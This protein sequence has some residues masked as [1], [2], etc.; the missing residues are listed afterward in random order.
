MDDSD[1]RDLDSVKFVT[2]LRSEFE[3]KRFMIKCCGIGNYAFENVLAKIG[4]EIGKIVYLKKRGTDNGKDTL[5]FYYSYDRNNFSDSNMI[6]LDYYYHYVD[7][8]SD[9]YRK[10]YHIDKS[11]VKKNDV[12]VL[13]NIYERKIKCGEITYYCMIDGSKLKI[14]IINNNGERFD[15]ISDGGNRQRE[16]FLDL[17]NNNELEQYIF[18][19]NF[20]DP[21]EVIFNKLCKLTNILEFTRKESYLRNISLTY[22]KNG[23]FQSSYEMIKKLDPGKATFKVMNNLGEIYCEFAESTEY[24][25]SQKKKKYSIRLKNGDYE[26]KLEFISDNIDYK[27]FNEEELRTYL[28][29]LMFP[30]KMEEVFKNISEISLRDINEYCRIYMSIYNDK[31]FLMDRIILEKGKLIEFKLTRDGRE[32]FLDKDG[33]FCYQSVDKISDYSVCMTGDIVTEYKYKCLSGI[34]NKDDSSMILYSA[35]REAK[36]AK[37]KTRKLIDEMMKN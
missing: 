19:I 30:V 8:I 33:N 28:L 9:S 34:D 10:K 3:I 5:V 25:E 17:E 18:N 24:Y 2:D 23:F 12:N 26:L 31:H 11:Y 29:N 27:I 13:N 1:I 36:E 15:F 20:N 21:L 32:F 14:M 4:F 16:K 35:I 37:I 22:L 6:E 7:V